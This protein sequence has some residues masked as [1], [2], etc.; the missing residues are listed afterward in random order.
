MCIVDLQHNDHFLILASDGV[1][2]FMDNQEAVDIV[3]KCSDDE[4]ACS[5]VCCLDVG[6]LDIKVFWYASVLC[7]CKFCNEADLHVWCMQLVAAA[8]EKWMEQED[9]SA[10]D[11]TAVIVRFRL[12]RS[13]ETSPPAQIN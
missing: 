5:K 9:G 2:E 3:S 13:A 8:H 11:I 7:V 1:W 12:R 6:I 10:D 4:T